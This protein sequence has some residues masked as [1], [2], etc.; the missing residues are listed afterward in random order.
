VNLIG[1][2]TDY[3]G[4]FVLPMAIDRATVVTATPRRDR[5]VTVASRDLG[6]SDRFSLDA[7]EATGSWRDYVRGI[8]DALSLENGVDLLI[9]SEVPRGVGLSSS[10]ALE[11][12]LARALSDAPAAE[13]ALLSQRVENDFV[14]VRC[15]IMDQLTVAVARANHALLLDC[16]DLTTR[17]I[18][19][20]EDAAILA[21]D[22]RIE[23]RLASSGYNERRA[24]CEEAARTIG[25]AT[26]RDATPDQ[27]AQ[28]P[29]SVRKPARHVIT[30]NTRTLAAAEALAQ[31]DLPLMGELMNE[32]HRSMR[33]DFEIVPSQLD[34]LAGAIRETPGCFG[35][36]L[37]GGGFGGAIV[38]LVSSDAIDAVRTRAE[39][40]GAVAYVCR[41]AD[42]VKLL[43]AD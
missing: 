32:S 43:G 4:G 19:M 28:L 41:A 27:V 12:A 42:G 31:G 39:A 11:V 29:S 2:H 30:E 3:N 34:A 17:H 36:R 9:E 33:D 40:L 20:P 10:A 35:A 1:E 22:S 23:R 18:A 13:L 8:V 7:I 24:G 21:C 16:R 26:L 37:T 14:G 6:E 38:S 25:V 15:G 5:I